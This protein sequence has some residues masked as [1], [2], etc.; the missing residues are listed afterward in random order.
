MKKEQSLFE[1]FISMC[2]L[3]RRSKAH[4]TRVGAWD[5]D[6]G[7]VEKARGLTALICLHTNDITISQGTRRATLRIRETNLDYIYAAREALKR[8]AHLQEGAATG[9]D[10]RRETVRRE[11]VRAVVKELS[12]Y[13]VRLP[14]WAK[15]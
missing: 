3:S 12:S 15:K 14:G 13:G 4:G 8:L 9:G 6:L 11:D 7:E 10:A 1:R 2:G 5:I